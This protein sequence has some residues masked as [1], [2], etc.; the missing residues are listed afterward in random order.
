MNPSPTNRLAL[1]GALLASFD[2]LHPLCDQWVQ[3]S[4][5]AA[6]KGLH[7]TEL[8]YRDG[9]PVAEN[10]WHNG[11]TRTASAHGRRAVTRHVASYTAVQLLAA[12]GVT[13]AFGIRVP[14][15]A[16]L[17]GAAINAGTH[18]I[19]DRRDPLIWLAGKAGKGGYIKH[20]TVV[21]KAGHD[22]AELSG[23]GTALMELDQAAHRAIGFAAAA[24]TTWYATRPSGSR[25]AR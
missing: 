15:K 12:A 14:V 19:L 18:A 25:G 5:D 13:R 10:P 21:R 11:P 7:G 8:V 24:V 22:T 23:P 9:T 17:A 4:K 16:L 6:A 20:A 3:S 1:F 2:A